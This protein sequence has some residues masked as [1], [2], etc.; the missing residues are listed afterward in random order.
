MGRYKKKTNT[1]AW[2]GFFTAWSELYFTE[3]FSN[4]P[5]SNIFKQ[6]ITPKELGISRSYSLR[7][8]FSSLWNTLHSTNAFGSTKNIY[9]GMKRWTIPSSAGF[10]LGHADLEGRGTP[11]SWHVRGSCSARHNSQRSAALPFGQV[12]EAA[13]PTMA[14][15]GPII[16]H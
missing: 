6:S 4:K 1:T 7:I 15:L 12:G 2:W 14:A 5:V 11:R 9:T 8:T 16:C 10:C 3:R 13:L